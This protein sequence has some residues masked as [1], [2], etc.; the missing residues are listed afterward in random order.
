MTAP[1]VLVLVETDPA[2]VS[3]HWHRQALALDAAAR[4]QGI[5]VLLI[6][7]SGIGAAARE[8]LAAAGLAPVTTPR[9]VGAVLLWWS[10]RAL[11]GAAD[12]AAWA[13]RRRHRRFPHQWMLLARCLA[14][15]AALRT[16]RALTGHRQPPVVLLSAAEGLHALA[17]LL[18]GTPHLRWVHQL[19]TTED[20]LLR[21][22]GALGRR[23]R[24][25]V[26][27]L[28]PKQ[29]LADRISGRF[30]TLPI[31]VLPFAPADA[32]PR[33]DE[34][35]RAYARAAL[36]VDE[37]ETVVCLVGGWWPHKDPG[38][39]SAALSLIPQ[40]RLHVLVAACHLDEDL[41][42]LL[43][44][45]PRVRV[46]ELVGHLPRERVRQVY[47]AADATLVLR[48]PGAADRESGLVA[49]ALVLG[50]P[51]ITTD[52]DP[53]QA[54][55]LSGRDWARVVPCA[56]P[57]ALAQVLR[58]LTGHR[59][60]RPAPDQAAALGLP[61]A[62]QCLEL[63]LRLHREL[64]TSQERRRPWTFRWSA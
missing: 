32:E 52:H 12:A 22:L 34:R 51:L 18:G 11:R 46:H 19:H 31:C 23:T 13:G 17:A 53:V 1:P 7:P 25:R 35:E 20:V 56:Q 4:T 6:T 8:G 48:H 36:G 14:E 49:D 57:P 50:V 39:L 5:R 62:Q 28:A 2:E 54:A 27:L 10:A 61:T 58:E 47:A 45:L 63:H 40:V 41:L 55:L 24:H 26:R 30:P 37:R 3:G 64:T 16:A 44:A 59:L 42:R 15:A 29:E 33:L 9:G 60:P 21:R 38:L 43:R